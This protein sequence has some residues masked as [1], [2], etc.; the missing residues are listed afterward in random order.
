MATLGQYNAA[1]MTAQEVFDAGAAHL[2]EQGKQSVRL[3][4]SNMEYMCA[5]SSPSGLLCGAAP[6]IQNYSPDMEGES[7]DGLI[8]EYGQTVDHCHLI[9]SLQDCH[10]LDC[11]DNWESALEDIAEEHD[12][13]TKVLE[14][15]EYA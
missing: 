10:D 11:P 7:W 5:Y 14:N 1:E 12:L 6:F 15:Y 2:L 13:S 9:A 8:A 4:I 3:N